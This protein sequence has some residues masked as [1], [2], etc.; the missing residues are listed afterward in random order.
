M[1]GLKA[2]GQIAGAQDGTLNFSPSKVTSRLRLT[3]QVAQDMEKY[4]RMLF[5][6]IGVSTQKPTQVS[7]WSGF[8]N[9]PV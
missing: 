2:L 5:R 1:A 6:T 3:L 4:S 7:E 9:K 8:N